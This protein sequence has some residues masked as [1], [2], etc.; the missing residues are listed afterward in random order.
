MS[1]I[2]SSTPMI[3]YTR[4]QLLL[5]S[6]SPLV[7]SPANMPELKDWFGADLDQIV[8]RKDADS[9]SNTRDRRYRRDIE[10]GDPSSR[11]SFRSA[12]SQPSQM[13]NFKHQSLRAG[14]RDKERD[15]DGD[16]ERERDREGQERLRHLSDKYDRDRMG[17]PASG[18]RGKE[19]DGTSNAS[20]RLTSHTQTSA[21]S[22]RRAENRDGTKKKTGEAVEDW[23]RSGEPSRNGREERP[24]NGR[25]E[26]RERPRSR[27]RASSRSKRDTSGARRERE[28]KREDR[29]S[30]GDRDDYRREKDDHRRENRDR[31]V[32]RD[33]EHDDPR[34]W[35]DDGKREERMAARR[36]RENKDK[37]SERDSAWESSSDRRWTTD[38]RSDARSKRPAR[39]RKSGQGDDPKDREERRDREREREKEP[40]WM[41]AYIPNG[42]SF[43][44]L[45]GKGSDGELDG[46]QVWKKGMKEK[47]M[48]EKEKEQGPLSAAGQGE[49]NI[50]STT[51]KVDATEKQLDEI[52]LFKLLMKREEEKKK[53]DLSSSIAPAPVNFALNVPNGKL[54]C[55]STRLQEGQMFSPGS[56]AMTV[57]ASDA[58]DSSQLEGLNLSRIQLHTIGDPLSIRSNS[59]PRDELVGPRTPLGSGYVPQSEHSLLA[60]KTNNESIATYNPPSAPRLLSLGRPPMSNTKSPATGNS[61]S[62][63]H[64]T[65]LDPMYN[66]YGTRPENSRPLAGFS[67]F[68]ESSRNSPR[69]DIVN[70]QDVLRRLPKDRPSP[71][72]DSSHLDRNSYDVNGGSYPGPRGSRFA[73]FFDNK[74]REP[75]G[76]LPKPQTPVGLSLP[77]PHPGQ[78][79]DQSA[80]EPPHGEQRT[81]EDIFTMLSNSSQGHRNVV[82]PPLTLG[83]NHPINQQTQNNLQL[84]QQAAYQQQQQIQNGHRM[85]PLYESRLDDRN[86]VPDGMVPGLRTIPPPR[87]R[88][89]SALYSDGL[90]E[91]MHHNLQ[92][93]SQQRLDS[94]Y[95]GPPPL[96]NHQRNVGMPVQQAHFRGAPSPIAGQQGPLQNPQRLPP[97]LANLG[98]RPPHDPSH[99]LNMPGVPAPNL[100]GSLPLNGLPQQNFN[101]FAPNGGLSYNGP[102]LRGLPTQQMQNSLNHAMNSLTAPNSLNSNHA[103]LL[104]MSGVGIGLRGVNTGL[105]PQQGQNAQVHNP[106]LSMRQQQPL[107]AHALP[108]MMP[109]HLSQQTLSGPT[110]Q[111]AHDLMA[112][113]MGGPHRE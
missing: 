43:G 14:D 101:A 92:R 75:A 60:D 37:P 22:S 78:R 102:P 52:Q 96:F 85:E 57:A 93:P 6:T 27:V 25:R 67:P 99:F 105:T 40:A 49:S 87:S 58:R 11:P 32:D 2:N 35:R 103:Q 30:R 69:E 18:P 71:N 12:I 3:V 42:P 65:S 70:T 62:I 29:S 63:A 54:P 82:N 81:L 109:P 20:S 56:C 84:L 41:D 26:D 38:E 89:A 59:G 36:E 51:D 80:H 68:E 45:G 76:P 28:D 10:D 95:A 107:P 110:N 98:G 55:G 19:R 74:A 15:R 73:K 9:S 24:E 79:A 8:L 112:L 91:A 86:F 21:L 94:V 77:S 44:I 34:H 61:P 66:Q 16:R 48:R 23:R 7:K 113:L 90:D 106:L 4:P 83:N 50:D 17:L 100:H 108:H 33:S 47:E 88:D 31:D 97:G 13:G 46:I 1:D 104:A 111:P 39:D 64:P 72:P 5:L 53:T